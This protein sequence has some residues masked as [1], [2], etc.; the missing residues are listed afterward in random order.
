ME[1][2]LDGLRWNSSAIQPMS[3][4]SERQT[5]I[6]DIM[7]TVAVRRRSVTACPM[8]CARH[9]KA[10]DGPEIER[11]CPSGFRPV[12]GCAGQ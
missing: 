6:R 1:P 8:G 12:Q 4:T 5:R 10:I 2:P 11:V 9:F 3:T 7:P